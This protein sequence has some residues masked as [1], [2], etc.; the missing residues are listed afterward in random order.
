MDYHARAFVC[1]HIF[2]ATHPVLLVVRTDEDWSLLC[3]D[4]H[5]WAIPDSL[6]LV[7]IGHILDRDSSLEQVMDLRSGCEAERQSVGAEWIRQ[8]TPED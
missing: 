5:D 3:G 1:S 2:E 4:E 7:G 6:R 8:F